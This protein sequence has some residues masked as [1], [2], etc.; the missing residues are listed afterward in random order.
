[1]GGISGFDTF[2]VHLLLR[3]PKFYSMKRCMQLYREM[4]RLLVSVTTYPN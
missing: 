4:D 2:W 3:L 1:M